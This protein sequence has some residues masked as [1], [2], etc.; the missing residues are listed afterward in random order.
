MCRN[1]VEGLLVEPAA[2]AELA[3]AITRLLESPALRSDMGQ[4]GRQRVAESFTPEGQ[5]AAIVEQLGLRN[6]QAPSVTLPSP[7]SLR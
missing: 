2:E 4:R 7:S 6:S 1:E 3:Q 5:V